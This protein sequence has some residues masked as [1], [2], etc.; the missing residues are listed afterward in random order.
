MYFFFPRSHLI[1]LGEDVADGG[2][3]ISVFPYYGKGFIY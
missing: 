3:Y 1:P 2:I